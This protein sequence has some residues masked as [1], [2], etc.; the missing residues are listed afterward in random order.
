M[1]DGSHIWLSAAGSD[2]E[3]IRLNTS[4]DVLQADIR[5][6]APPDKQGTIREICTD[7]TDMYA[8]NGEFI[9]IISQTDG[10]I[11][12]SIATPG[13]G[14]RGIAMANDL[15]YCNDYI[16]DSVYVFNSSEDTWQAVFTTPIPPQG[17]TGNRYPT[18]MA[19][20]GV[21]FWLANSTY[22]YDYIFQ[23]DMSG[24][25]IRTFEVPGR[26]DA[27][28]TGVLFTRE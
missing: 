1:F 11:L 28:P 27:Q 4:E 24:N 14:A 19:F 17:S 25:V 22:E 7:G 26:G 12:N 2:D 16:S 21:N 23:V 13:S 18:G 8:L 20:D 10:S 3:I 9:Y 6:D 5:L 15:L